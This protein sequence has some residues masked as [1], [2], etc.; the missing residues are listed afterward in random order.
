MN[1]RLL[2]VG[3]KTRFKPGISPNPGGRPKRTPYT[4][5]C[6]LVAEMRV[7]DLKINARD[8]VPLAIAKMVAREALRGKV[9]AAA[10]LANRVEGTP[11]QRHELGGPDGM[12]VKVEAKLSIGDL[13]GAI[14]EIYGLEDLKILKGETT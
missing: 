4:D 1:S 7:K 10:E 3:S 6:R 2:E 11:T 14:R 9:Q 12:A 13:F 5:A 8:P